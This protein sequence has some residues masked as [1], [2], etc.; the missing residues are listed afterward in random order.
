MLNKA[1]KAAGL[2]GSV[3]SDGQN[4]DKHGAQMSVRISAVRQLTT[5]ILASIPYKCKGQHLKPCVQFR[6]FWISFL[7]CE[8][9]FSILNLNHETSR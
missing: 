7:S 6:Q 2:H 3:D 9:S 4:K 8:S 5:G 1:I